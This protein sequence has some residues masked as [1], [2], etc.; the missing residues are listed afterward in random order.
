MNKK[1]FTKNSAA[2]LMFLIALFLFCGFRSTDGV[3]VNPGVQSVTVSESLVDSDGWN[4]STLDTARD[5]SYLSDVEKDVILELNKAR[6]NPKKWAEQNLVPRLD[7]F[8]GSPWGDNYYR[9]PGNSTYFGTSEGKKSLQ[10]C[11]ADMS[12]RAAMK[13]LA[14]SEALCSAARDHVEDVGSKGISGHNGTDGSNPSAR[15][16]RYGLYGCG[17]NISYGWPGAKDI[18]IQLLVDDGVPG[19]GHRRNCFDTRYTIVGVAVGYHA[20]HDAMCVMDLYW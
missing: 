20:R 4:I 8:Q 10:E 17:E 3:N 14:V 2:M 18:L 5:V 13:P 12:R 1:H 11:I 7:W 19:R 16:K 15:A 6:A 9:L